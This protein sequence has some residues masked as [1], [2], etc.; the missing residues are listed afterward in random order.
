ME[1]PQKTILDLVNGI[2]IDYFARYEIEHFSPITTLRPDDI[3]LGVFSSQEEKLESWR[4]I[5]REELINTSIIKTRTQYLKFIDTGDEWVINLIASCINSLL[6]QNLTAHLTDSPS[7]TLYEISTLFFFRKAIGYQCNKF[8]TLR[9]VGGYYVSG[10]MMGNMAALLIARNKKYPDAQLKGIGS[11]TDK[12][13]VPAFSTHYSN[14]NVAGWLG[15]GEGSVIH[16]PSKNFSYDIK[17]LERIVDDLYEKGGSVLM[18]TASLGDPYTMSI[19]TNLQDIRRLCDKYNIWMHGDGANGAVLKLSTLYHNR[20]SGF[21]LCDSITIDPHKALGLNYPTSLF[22]C[23]NITYF[24]SVISNWN[25][26]NRPDS[27]DMGMITPFLNSRGFDSLRIWLALRLIGKEYF[28]NAIDAKISTTEFLFNTCASS[29]Y[30]IR[31]NI[32]QSFAFVFQVMPRK[33][34]LEIIKDKVI[35][36][37]VGKKISNIQREF[38]GWIEN[39]HGI[40]FHYFDLPYL[41]RY[42]N[43]ITISN[44]NMM[45]TVIALHN[46]HKD[47][48]GSFPDL[49]RQSIDTFCRDWSGN[50]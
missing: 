48:D 28:S 3:E 21:E 29:Q 6:N 13:I 32:P 39:M 17:Q 10:G 38:M 4:D 24:N 9:D 7:A 41:S 12:I 33:I 20:S 42:Y 18:I 31:W 22:L 5:I 40:G 2:V 36:E 45:T 15:F 44:S 30:F 35:S 47:I 49:I 37:E 11:V 16:A 27:L 26:I 50:D 25:I 34:H 43:D 1:E 23:R 19:E 46:G 14:W 8:K